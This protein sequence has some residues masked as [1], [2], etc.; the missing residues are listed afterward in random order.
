MISN[1]VS[2]SHTT[3]TNDEFLP[4]DEDPDP[5]KLDFVL[6][7]C[8]SFE[9]SRQSENATSISK[10]TFNIQT[11]ASLF[12]DARDYLKFLLNQDACSEILGMGWQSIFYPGYVGIFVCP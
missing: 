12:L 10:D 5:V 11:N 9:I 1:P 2:F 8:F 7:V 3:K 6:F 4:N